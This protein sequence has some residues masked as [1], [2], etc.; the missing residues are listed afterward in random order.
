MSNVLVRNGCELELGDIQCRQKITVRQSHNKAS[1]D[2]SDCQLHPGRESQL[3]ETGCG[4]PY[5]LTLPSK[6]I[7]GDRRSLLRASGKPADAVLL[8][9]RQIRFAVAGIFV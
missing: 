1:R 6:G 3:L 8:H 9:F 5:A 7:M 2:Y 4:A